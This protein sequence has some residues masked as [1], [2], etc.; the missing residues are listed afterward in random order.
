MNKQEKIVSIISVLVILASLS[1]II[2]SIGIINQY[3][4]HSASV[5]SSVSN[6]FY[7]D[8][9]NRSSGSHSGSDSTAE[10]FDP[11][12]LEPSYPPEWRDR[13]CEGGSVTRIDGQMDKYIYTGYRCTLGNKYF[14][15]VNLVG[16]QC[17]ESNGGC[18]VYYSDET[19]RVVSNKMKCVSVIKSSSTAACNLTPEDKTPLPK[20]NPDFCSDRFAQFPNDY[21][22][23]PCEVT[24]HTFSVV[25]IPGKTSFFG[26]N[27]YDNKNLI[28]Q[29]TKSE[30]QSLCNKDPKCRRD[31]G[32]GGYIAGDPAFGLNNV[33]R[34]RE[35]NPE[36]EISPITGNPKGFI[37]IDGCKSVETWVCKWTA[38]IY[39][40]PAVKYENI[41]Y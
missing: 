20:G 13:Q 38:P 12:S 41:I 29:M 4:Q 1:F 30:Q 22:T 40:D 25:P 7:S 35:K 6:I 5:K 15:S 23:N 31:T 18:S 17:L 33:A 34:E 24:R 11:A 16:T 36:A 27:T 3:P 28:Q 21:P 39:D 14:E 10:P 32:A 19:R 37:P 26:P 9:D 2:K 8:R